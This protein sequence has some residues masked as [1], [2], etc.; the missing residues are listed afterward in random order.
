MIMYEQ[1]EEGGGAMTRYEQYEDTVGTQSM[2][3]QYEERGGT[4]IVYEQYEKRNAVHRYERF[5]ERGWARRCNECANSMKTAQERRGATIL[6]IN[7]I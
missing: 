4:I 1:Y 2:N 7:N 3:E 6:L 5:G